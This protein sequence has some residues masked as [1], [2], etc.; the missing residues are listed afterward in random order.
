[1]AITPPDG[2]STNVG[3]SRQGGSGAEVERM[4]TDERK[5]CLHQDMT[6]TNPATDNMGRC[7]EHGSAMCTHPTNDPMAVTISGPNLPRPLCD[8]GDMHVHAAGC[9]DLRKYPTE[10]H[11]GEKGWTITVASVREVVEN[12]YGDQIRESGSTW[13]DYVGDFYWAPC[14][15]KLAEDAS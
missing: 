13:Q 6:T 15:S 7:S 9:A 3:E 4:L 2:E 10:R 14:T 12:V 1:M 5:V 11:T 8:K